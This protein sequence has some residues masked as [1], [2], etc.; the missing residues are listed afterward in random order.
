MRSKT[1]ELEEAQLDRVVRDILRVV[2]KANAL[3]DSTG[4]EQNLDEHHTLARR[5]ASEAITLLKNDGAVLP[6]APATSIRKIAVIGEFAVSPRY[7]GNGSSEVK[8]CPG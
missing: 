8:A 6:V 5:V 2:V 1:G 7:Q 3:A 4:R